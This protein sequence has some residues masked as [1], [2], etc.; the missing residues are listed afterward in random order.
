MT[1]RRVIVLG[2]LL[3]ACRQPPR[4][5]EGEARGEAPGPAVDAAGRPEAAAK[6][7]DGGVAAE[8]AAP[9]GG[10]PP[11]ERL[12]REQAVRDTKHLVRLLE[13]SHPDP[14]TRLGGK[15]AFHRKV[16]A[17]I[18]SLPADG[19]ATRE[20]ADRLQT[21]LG[22]LHDGHTHL[23]WETGPS[24]REAQP[25]AV[26]VSF[27]CSAGGPYL[28]A[29]DAA[30]L[31]GTRGFRLRAVE[32][33]PYEELAERLSAVASVENRHGACH[34]LRHVVVS[35]T[36]LARLVP[37]ADPSDG[38]AYEL[39]APDGARE[40]RTVPSSAGGAA[41]DRSAWRSPPRRFGAVPE[42]DE[43]FHWAMVC[44][45]AGAYFRVATIMGR[46]AY[47]LAYR[48]GWGDPRKMIG[49]FYERRKREMPADIEEALRGIPSFLEEGEELLAA[50]KER[51]TGALIIDLRGNGGGVTPSVLPFLLAMYGDR[52]FG[53]AS[54]IQWVHVVS[55]LYL[56]KMNKTADEW[57]Q[58]HDDPLFEAGDFTFEEEAA[59]GSAEAE[60]EEL[61]AGYRNDGM[62][63]AERLAALGGRP[64]HTP[65]RVLVLSDGGT[66]SAAFHFLLYLRALGA[67]VVGVPPGQAP[68]AFMETTP[69]TLPESRLEGTISNS[70]QVCLPDDPGA[71]ELLPDVPLTYEQARAL[72]FEEDAVVHLAVS[73]V[74]GEARAAGGGAGRASGGN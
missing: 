26:P 20:F 61:I 60:R 38:I 65:S 17:L 15:V 56:D 25:D 47:E 40:T 9:E 48:R 4:A 19:I 51:R 70:A 22:R 30:D 39:E 67:T 34:V 72:D 35:P 41:A 27:A 10:A 29:F 32:G 16:R 23:K 24:W 6:P 53:I 69:F 1:N 43:P 13:L 31:E 11:P 71:T 42:S 14:Y 7:G 62:A 18:D 33:L 44:D 64:I 46:E 21:F 49:Q 8:D 54:P 50:M 5:G 55:Q 58:E 37:Q 66:F 12:S 2:L 68:N 45:S 59:P 74:C 3:V 36:L 28:S 63:F 52:A 73:R 57:R